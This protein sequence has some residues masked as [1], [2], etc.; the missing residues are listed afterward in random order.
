MSSW[1]FTGELAGP[2]YQNPLN[3]A[4]G[5]R[6]NCDWDHRQNFVT[7]LV[8]QSP[9][10]GNGFVR[11]LSKDWMLSPIFT[12]ATGAPFT[13]TDGKDVSLTGQNNDRPNVVAPGQVF[14]SPQA[15][16]PYWFNP[17]AFRYAGSDAAC[18]TLSGQFGNLGRNAMYS[19]GSIGRDMSLS[20]QFHP[21][22]H[23]RLD[24]RSDFFNI[25]NHANWRTPG[26][27]V[28]TSGTFGAVT[29]FGD[30]RIVQMAVKLYF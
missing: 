11:Q 17:A 20:P 18:S 4:Q 26:T 24:V 7:I 14:A 29:T 19:P 23:W 6:G 8:V 12:L 1:D 16:L 30:P 13:I 21:R 15:A 9:G 28:S 25:L 2:Q 22:E 27:T 3:R 5:E 10:L